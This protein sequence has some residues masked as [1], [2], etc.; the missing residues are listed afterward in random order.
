MRR[1]LSFSRFA[2]TLLLFASVSVLVMATA[3]SETIPEATGSAHPTPVWF[4]LNRGVVGE[5]FFLDSDVNI[6]LGSNTNASLTDLKLGEIAHIS[7][8]IENGRWLAHEI[9][10][11]PLHGSRNENRSNGTRMRELHAHGRILAYNASTGNLTI[12]YHR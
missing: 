5:S 12:K 4:H 7:Y 8:T 3:R 9:V 1:R 6:H 10:V 2:G 11:S